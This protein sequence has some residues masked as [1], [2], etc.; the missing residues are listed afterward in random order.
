[1]TYLLNKNRYLYRF[2]IWKDVIIMM[3]IIVNDDRRDYLLGLDISKIDPNGE[4]Y[5]FNKNPRATLMYQKRLLTDEDVIFLRNYYH[6]KS[7]AVN[8]VR[9][10]KKANYAIAKDRNKYNEKSRIKKKPIITGKRIIIG[11][12]VILLVWGGHRLLTPKAE[13]V[14]N[15]PLG[16]QTTL[17]TSDGYQELEEETLLD[18]VNKDTEIRR[19]EV[20][21]HLCNIFQ[22]D[23]VTVYNKLK[24]MSNNFSS[25]DYL[26]GHLEGISCK[27]FEVNATSEDE[28]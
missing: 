17:Y 26:N 10:I 2:F 6:D 1:M 16:Y 13:I 12:L 23:Y 7:I 11:G 5:Y 19:M 15:T 4:Y 25:E 3:V 18:I 24:E 28:L 27:G 20:I 14:D 22:V 9:P 8:R 21:K